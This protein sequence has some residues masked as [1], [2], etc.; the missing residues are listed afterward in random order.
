L[1]FAAHAP[2]ASERRLAE[3][4]VL[5]VMFL[6]AGNFIVV[7]SAVAQLP[8]VAFTFLRFLL[9][10]ATLLVLLRLREGTIGLPRRDFAAILGLGALGFGLYQILWTT[11]LTMI[12]A[13]DS[14]LIIAATPVIVAILSVVARSDVLTP[15]KLA[16]SLISFFGVA[17]V[18]GSGP[19]FSIGGSIAG[20]LIT[21]IAAIC[22]GTYT[23][24]AA[25]FLGR[26]SPLRTTAWATV[27][28]TIVL[29]LP[30]VLQLGSVSTGGLDFGAIAG[31]I[32]YS[33]LLAAGI[34]NVVVLHGVK[35]AGPTRTAALQFLV[36][37]LAVLLAAVFL[38]EEIRPGQVLGGG[39]IVGGVILTR[40]GRSP[41]ALRI[42]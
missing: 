32:L 8:P 23:A 1:T 35:L 2:T 21:L 30:G 6:W 19:G 25:P 22:W 27:A 29:A 41:R 38:H 24:F 5:V 9:A 12:Q 31:A 15:I 39:V 28:G 26:H 13:G 16:G 18:I 36:P 20:D 42:G 10:S 3:A 40:I 37:A 7:K 4:G 11:G 17:I 34:A 14:A 33:G